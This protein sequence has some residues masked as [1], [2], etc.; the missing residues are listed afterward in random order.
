MMAEG[1]RQEA[2]VSSE[3]ENKLH[4]VGTSF[5]PAA[6]RVHCQRRAIPQ[7]GQICPCD[8]C[9]SP[10]AASHWSEYRDGIRWKLPLSYNYLYKGYC[11]AFSALEILYGISPILKFLY[12]IQD[13]SR[14]S[15]NTFELIHY[16]DISGIN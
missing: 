9:T 8:L 2:K 16:I 12:G 6:H 15:R 4:Q 3:Q 11:K 10:P 14:N 13:M 1:G 5:L 7:R